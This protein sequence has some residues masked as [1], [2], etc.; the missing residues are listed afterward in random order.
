VIAGVSSSLIGMLMPILW[1]MM[2]GYE[3]WDDLGLQ[4]WAFIIGYFLVTLAALLLM[5]LTWKAL[6]IAADPDAPESYAWSVTA[7]AMVLRPCAIGLAGLIWLLLCIPC[8]QMYVSFRYSA[9]DWTNHPWRAATVVA[10]AVMFTAQVFLVP[11]FIATWGCFTTCSYQRMA[12]EFLRR[13][14]LPPPPPAGPP[15]DPWFA[16]NE[17]DAELLATMRATARPSLVAGVSS[18]LISLLAAV[19][20]ISLMP[21]HTRNDMGVLGW[22][23]F[24]IY[25]IMMVYVIL[26]VVLTWN[27]L[28][29]AA[30]PDA[31]EPSAWFV[32]DFAPMVRAFAIGL[33][34]LFWMLLCAI[35]ALKKGP[36]RN[37]GYRYAYGYGQATIVMAMVVL[38]IIQAFVIPISIGAWGYFTTYSYQRIVQEFKRRRQ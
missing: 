31:P 18:A 20:V 22:V 8:I 26:W 11:I 27:A 35:C 34:V 23:G 19:L 25:V 2:I 1:F 21:R 32:T 38:T 10:S 14:Q 9:F 16:N 4:G 13:R 29:V 36:V 30:D 24:G 37:S 5:V 28:R 15:P 12:R 17:I 7:W 6:R 33:A 3:R